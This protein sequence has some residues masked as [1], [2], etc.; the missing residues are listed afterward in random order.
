ME[1]TAYRLGDVTGWSLEPAPAQRDWMDATLGKRAYRCLP[2][3]I[4]NQCGWIVRMPHSFAASW[5]GDADPAGTYVTPLEVTPN[6]E[7]QIH[8]NFGLGIISFAL[9]W[10]FR[11]PPGYGILITGLLNTFKP[12]AC[13]LSG[14]VETDWAP[15][16]FTMNWRITTPNVQVKWTRD[17]PICMLIPF[18]LDALETFEPRMTVVAENP[19]LQEAHASWSRERR[20]D[21]EE[22]RKRPGDAQ[23]FR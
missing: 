12:H 23:K 7:G 3:T 9:P 18:Q 19:E 4:A 21:S 16:S 2:L 20:A 17:E 13:A 15:Y 6:F 22:N 8:T 5:S 10:L 14:M 11:T 1:I